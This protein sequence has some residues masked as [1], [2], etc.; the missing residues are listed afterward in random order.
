MPPH[1]GER[2]IEPTLIETTRIHRALYRLEIWYKVCCDGDMALEVPQAVLLLRYPAWELDEMGCVYEYLMTRLAKIIEAIAEAHLEGEDEYY[3][4][5][6]ANG[7]SRGRLHLREILT[8]AWSQT[9]C[10]H[11]VLHIG[12]NPISQAVCKFSSL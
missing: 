11:A 5:L 6:F 9:R 7:K 2:T 12:S 3:R 4:L 10:P 8:N 1:D